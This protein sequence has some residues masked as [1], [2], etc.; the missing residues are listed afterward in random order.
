MLQHMLEFPSFY[1][2][3]VVYSFIC[4]WILGFL[5]LLCFM[6]NTAINRSVQI[7]L[8]HTSFSYFGCILRNEIAVSHS[9][10]FLFFLFVFF[11]GITIY[12]SIAATA[13]I[14][15]PPTGC[16]DSSFSTFFL[17]IFCLFLIVAI[18]MD[19]RWYCVVVLICISLMV[20]DV[21]H[22]FICL[23]AICISSLVKFL[24]KSF[25]HVLNRV[26]FG[27]C[28]AVH[29]CSVTHL[30]L[31]LCDPMDCS[32][33]GSSVHGIFQARIL[34]LVGISYSR[35]LSWPRDGRSPESPALGGGFFTT[36]PPGKPL[37]NCRVFK[38]IFLCYI[39]TYIYMHMCVCVCVCV[40]SFQIFFHILLVAFSCCWL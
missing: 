17:A 8:R 31:T 25:A 26:Y 24:F 2:P 29:G 9:N 10:F 33:P 38:N 13:A 4:P 6:N 11:W 40:C 16:K 19:V 7:F 3:H 12:F 20:T 34:E 30:C 23:L 35:G 15:I 39:Y 28:W 32:P 1:V 27:C 22:L 18:L 14:S 37:L 36:Q 21:E 5:P